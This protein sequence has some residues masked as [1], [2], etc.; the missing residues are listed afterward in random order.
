MERL[1]VKLKPNFEEVKAADW[2][3]VSVSVSSFVLVFFLFVTSFCVCVIR[4]TRGRKSMAQSSSQ[5]LKNSKMAIR[6]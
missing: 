1:I 6:L 4:C 5:V 2:K 3:A